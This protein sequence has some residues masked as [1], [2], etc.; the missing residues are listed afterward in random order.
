[1]IIEVPILP[2]VVEDSKNNEMVVKS[3]TRFDTVDIE[4]LLTFFT[5]AVCFHFFEELYS[6][7]TTTTISR[8]NLTQERIRSTI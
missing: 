5:L 6:K 7:D 1:M 3:I 2:S 4:Q 8:G